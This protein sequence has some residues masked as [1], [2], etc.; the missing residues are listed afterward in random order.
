MTVHRHPLGGT[1]ELRVTRTST[2]L[3]V[4]AV[5]D[6]DKCASG[7]LAVP[8][9]QLAILR[10]ALE[11]MTIEIGHDRAANTGTPSSDRGTP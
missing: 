9:A 8:V 6:Q 5:H 7:P 10:R 11:E 1:R 3:V 2:G 4:L